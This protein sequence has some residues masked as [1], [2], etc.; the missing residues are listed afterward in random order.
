MLSFYSVPA[1]KPWGRPENTKGM[2]GKHQ[3]FRALQPYTPTGQGGPLKPSALRVKNILTRP[4]CYE[5]HAITAHIIFICSHFRTQGK[6]T[7]DCNGSV[8]H[9]KWQ[10]PAGTLSM[11]LTAY[12]A[13]CALRYLVPERE[14][15]ANDQKRSFCS[16][17][18]T[19]NHGICDKKDAE[20]F[21][22]PRSILLRQ[23]DPTQQHNTKNIQWF[24][25]ARCQT[26]VQKFRQVGQD[27]QFHLKLQDAPR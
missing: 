3:K 27:G 17:E 11:A 13:L 5:S 12:N 24:L 23:R 16:S 19:K 20:K 14:P 25:Y 18:A 9:E 4:E 6:F 8:R 15:G 21:H 10:E 1:S 22:C 26:A 7:T 2:M